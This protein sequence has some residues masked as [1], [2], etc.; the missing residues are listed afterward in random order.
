[1]TPASP[2][3][4]SWPPAPN[5]A[6]PT[7][8]RLAQR[9]VRLTARDPHWS[10][11]L[12]GD[13][14]EEFAVLAERRGPAAARR[15]YWRQAL[16][17]T[18]AAL[19][20]VAAIV[21]RS[22]ERPMRTLAN[23]LRLAARTLRRQ[24]FVTAIVVLT[25]ALALG[26]N[27][28]TFGMIDALVLHPFTI[29]DVDR[30]VLLS[31]N[32]A[33]DP[34]PR[35]S[36][37]AA[38]F[39][40]LKAQIGGLD[41]VSAFLWWDVNLAGGNRPE[42]IQGFTVSGDFF[43]TV[44]AVVE[45]GRLLQPRDMVPGR[46]RVAV[47]SDGL[48]RRRFGADPGVIGRSIRLGGEPYEVVGVTQPGFDF[49]Q[50]AEVWAPLVFTAAEAANRTGRYLTV[51]GRLAP[52]V[53]RGQAA[54]EI[55]QVYARVSAAHP[56]AN[57]GH[58][59]VVRSFTE[60]M[61]DIGLPQILGLWQA[62]AALILLI[63]CANITSLLL[64]RGA[65][66]QRELA[67]RLAIGAGRA[68]IIRQLLGESLLL[69]ALSLPAAL[70]VAVVIFRLIQ[71]AMPAELIRF[72][73]GWNHMGVDPRL[74]LFTTVAAMA[75]V[76][77]SGLLPAMQSSRPALTT[78]LKDGGRSGSGGPARS[79]LR[80][81]L[82]AAEIA[83]ALPL[84]VVSGLAA[85]GSQRFASGPQGYD[86]DG[87]YLTRVV[88]PEA[89][90]P[91]ADARRRFTDGWIREAAVIPEVERVATTSVA[92]ATDTNQ[93]RYLAIDGRASDPADEQAV[94]FRAVSPAYFAT[95]RIPVL[96]GRSVEDRDRDDSEP[97]AVITQSMAQRYWPGQSPLQHQI[98]LGRNAPR[99][100][101][102]VGVVGDTVDDW[103]DRRRTPTA[104]VPVAQDPQTTVMLVA[105]TPGDPGSLAA[106]LR[107]ALARV[108][109]DQA[110]FNDMTMRE[111]IYVR[112]TGLRF[113]GN[114]MAAFG[115][116]AL[117]LAA[118]GIYAVMAHSVAQ[119]RHEI[120]IRMALGATPRGV[121]WSTMASG[122]RLTAIG[123]AIGL[124]AAIALARLMESV[125][126]GVVSAEPSLFVAVT[127]G[128]AGIAMLASLLPA[129]RATRVD[130]VVAIRGE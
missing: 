11:V 83:L 84:L 96:A 12:L 71:A 111:A 99:W 75:T 79:R 124:L 122:V 46:G 19:G 127:A 112:T 118:F 42:R 104:F 120:G 87:L 59:L 8:P 31:E 21:P 48:W 90:Y 41:R 7:P 85:L 80:R 68:R 61:I 39:I 14:R 74:L 43:S 20:Q 86:P 44:G 4:R 6:W 72:V 65:E 82:V 113:I 93:S 18:A 129:R 123:A 101:T 29:P 67:L 128:L 52:G 66:R 36:V 10:D 24:P 70:G 63:G 103:F 1:M 45:R 17:L 2:P 60:G 89:T 55:S 125:L 76:L 108:D 13:L 95:M 100:L 54:G 73:P 121:L 114:L 37:S 15:W 130:P 94:N 110:S 58:T 117:A 30:L 22:G 23:E 5:P 47:I 62:A 105:R 9:L 28:A 77:L 16:T 107:A 3:P 109:P 106:P 27:A 91:D 81:G 64:A 97:V 32:T 33:A 98:R 57:R 34:Y 56:D 25:L 119:R 50:G 116:L 49:P 102:V 92:P 51:I 126:F 26:S 35:E 40:D 115:L 38:N 88:L 53:S 69:A 78:A